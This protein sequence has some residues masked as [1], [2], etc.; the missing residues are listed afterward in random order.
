VLGAC[1]FL[2]FGAEDMEGER[3]GGGPGVVPDEAVHPGLGHEFRVG[4]GRVEVRGEPEV[5]VSAGQGGGGGEELLTGLDVFDGDSRACAG[6]LE[7]L[8]EL[9][10]ASGNF[11]D[12]LIEMIGGVAEFVEVGDLVVGA[13][14]DGVEDHFEAA[15]AGE[16][17]D[18]RGTGERT[19]DGGNKP[20]AGGAFDPEGAGEAA[21][22]LEFDGEVGEEPT[23]VLSEPLEGGLEAAEVVLAE[24][25][26]GTGLK[27]CSFSG[28]GP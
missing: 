11:A 4:I 2:G 20:L 17:G 12:D 18:E 28:N 26:S 8:G 22:G 21:G 19:G 23:E 7:A 6:P 9:A 10:S 3:D 16:L 5:R 1:G 27:F 15:A 25:R 14:D 24:C 13:G